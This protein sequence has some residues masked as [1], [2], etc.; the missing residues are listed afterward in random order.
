MRHRKLN[1]SLNRTKSHRKAA[2]KNMMRGILTN[3]RIVTTLKKAKVAS[4]WTD[5][6][7]TLSK[8]NNL[9]AIRKVESILQD[10]DLIYKLF[11]EIGPRFADRNGGY[12]RVLK[13]K[14]R[15][16]D[17]AELAILELTERE[18]MSIEETERKKKVES[19]TKEPSVEQIEQ[20]TSSLAEPQP[21]DVAAK[22][23]NEVLSKEITE[24]TA[25]DAQSNAAEKDSDNSQ[26]SQEETEKK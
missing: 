20:T 23:E 19:K 13:Y 9:A 26:D 21:V 4:K 11:H 2:V 7:I 10:K 8:K 16:G 25:E 12:T 24:E 17:G 5:K 6:I 15:R 22:E 3:E 18:V 1:T 14:T